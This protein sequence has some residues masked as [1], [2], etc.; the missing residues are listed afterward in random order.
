MVEKPAKS[1]FSGL[2][3]HIIRMCYGPIS[4]TSNPRVGSS[5]LSERAK[6]N[7]TL[8][9]NLEPACFPEKW[10]WEATGKHC[11]WIRLLFARSF[12]RGIEIISA[13]ALVALLMLIALLRLLTRMLDLDDPSE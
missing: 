8:T 7:Q 12:S 9:T 10:R 13:V 2:P 1:G 5:N 3:E 11:R 4:Q 6:Q